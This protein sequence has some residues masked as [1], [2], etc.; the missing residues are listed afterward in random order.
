MAE[1]ATDIFGIV[2]KNDLDVGFSF[3]RHHRSPLEENSLFTSYSKLEEEMKNE[4]SSIYKG[5][6]VVTYGPEGQDSVYF[7]PFL[8]KN[9]NDKGNTSYY[10]DRIITATYQS[11][12][13]DNIYVKKE[14]LGTIYTG[15]GQWADVQ[16]QQIASNTYSELF[17]D[18]RGNTI[19]LHENDDVAQPYTAYAHAEGAGN[20][21]NASYAHAEGLYTAVYNG[22]GA[23]VEGIGAIANGLAS[24]AEGSAVAKG[25]YSHAGGN[26]NTIA[27]GAYSFANG[28]DAQ[29]KGTGSMSV[30]NNTIATGISSVAI[31]NNTQA[32]GEYTVAL[33]NNTQAIGSS[34]TT[35]GYGTYAYG[36]SSHAEG[37]CSYSIGN[38]SHA[39][40]YNSYANKDY[41]HAEG[42]SIANGTYS[43]AEGQAQ[44]I[45]NYSHAEGQAQANNNY[46][47]AEG[48]SI[49]TGNYSHAEGQSIAQSDSSHAEGI[50]NATG[51]YSHAEGKGQS[52]GLASHAEGTSLAKGDYAH[53]E[54]NDTK[55]LSE[56][57]HS[58]GF[59]T[60]AYLYSHSEGYKSWASGNYSHAEGYNS[61]AMNIFTHA[62][63]NNTYALGEYT[64][65]EGNSNIAQGNYSH[66]EGLNS[67]SYGMCAHTEGNSVQAHG[68]S[69]HAEGYNTRANNDYSHAEGY[70]SYATGIGSHVEGYQNVA[71]GDY[72]HAEGYNT[73]SIGYYSHTSGHNT[74]AKGSYSFAIGF[75]TN[76][77]GIGSLSVGAVTQ[78]RGDYSL[79][80]GYMNISPNA[81]EFSNGVMNRSYTTTG[82]EGEKIN[83]IPNEF[84][85][86]GG[87]YVAGRYPTGI[88]DDNK[89]EVAYY[90][91]SYE[92]I[93]TIG[94]GST[95][96]TSVGPNPLNKIDGLDA[97]QYVK[98]H[99]RH[100]VMDIRKNGQ[101]YYDGGMI[102][103]GEIVAPMSYSYVASLGPT[104][105][106]TTIMAALLTQPEYYRPTLTINF[107]GSRNFN[108]GA[109]FD[110][111]VG[112]KVNYNMNFTANRVAYDCQQHLDP[113]YGTVL[114]NMLGYT[115]GI[116]KITYEL[117]PVSYESSTVQN[118]SL[119]SCAITIDRIDDEKLLGDFAAVPTLGKDIGGG[120]I[121][122][123]A[124]N[125]NS[126]NRTT[127]TY[128]NVL[129]SGLVIGTEDTY[130][131]MKTT[132]YTWSEASQMYFQQLAEKGTYIGAAGT[133]PTEKWDQPETFTCSN[134]TQIQGR[135][136]IYWGATK[137]TSKEL[138]TAQDKGLYDEGWDG[139]VKGKN[140]EG[141]MY[142]STWANYK[143]GNNSINNI[144]NYT[145]STSVSTIWVAAPAALFGC[146]KSNSVKT[147]Y[148]YYTNK[149]G[150]VGL[151]T[152]ITDY[153]DLMSGPKKGGS[154]PLYTY[155][156]YNG[157]G[158]CGMK[159]RVF[160]FTNK[161]NTVGDNSS[162]KFGMSIIK[163]INHIIDHDFT[164][165]EVLTQYL[166]DRSGNSQTQTAS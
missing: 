78:A 150:T 136:I 2:D 73:K 75:G 163:K 111:E 86:L 134:I 76:T 3:R 100:N 49:A 94:N 8:I 97:G 31:G 127:A 108:A 139:L 165:D 79:A 66:A 40:G 166:Y 56:G 146:C 10:A 143:G 5:Q 95:T 96:D 24:H 117:C 41:S 101:M 132:S 109:T 46:S 81:Y 53:A 21:I 138:Q 151:D 130:T 51:L 149:L 1:K 69:S 64:H 45:G 55:A 58:E 30:G 42:N 90:D 119:T 6:I 26:E 89:N 161:N 11:N 7:T 88:T 80:S 83:K 148:I 93:F 114:G 158:N 12:Y 16:G 84:A 54:G 142:W 9:D 144:D 115:R 131:L 87:K 120:K 23:H 122:N 112:S 13:I 137:K 104:A 123:F 28:V 63:G 50:G 37:Y 141:N 71:S 153:D 162:T 113:I 72:S 48:Q 147:N 20:Y 22:T 160:A 67:V 106:F 107:N 85:R 61:Y 92:T 102:V 65:V 19:T 32:K 155:L 47:H 14:Q 159:Y 152:G 145:L 68:A 98:V 133:K 35:E 25:A 38:Y 17:N 126:A 18:Y 135:Y 36:I 116:T 74:Y 43:H 128:I 103:G 77:Y 105:Y 99:S 44:A 60:T 57:A 62:E 154:C 156:T 82:E 129:G 52:I 27:E 91:S 118:N 157:I 125:P 70:N 140:K 15:V 121:D 39:E 34:S 164:K 110:I 59:Q 4:H 124:Y 29:A 33:G